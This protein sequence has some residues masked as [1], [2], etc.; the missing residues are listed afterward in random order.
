MILLKI[1]RSSKSAS[2]RS[3]SCLMKK[4][5]LTE[6]YEKNGLYRGQLTDVWIDQR[7][8]ELTDPLIER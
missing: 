2:K 4:V 1:F 3:I 7:T 8:D 6:A 5:K